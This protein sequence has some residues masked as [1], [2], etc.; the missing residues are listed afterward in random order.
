MQCKVFGK[1]YTLFLD[2]RGGAVP[3]IQGREGGGGGEGGG[4]RR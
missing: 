2:P 1:L 3:Y 4:A